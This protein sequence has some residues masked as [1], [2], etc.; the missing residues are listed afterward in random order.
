[1]PKKKLTNLYVVMIAIER[2]GGSTQAIHTE[3]AAIEAFGLT[4]TRFG[5]RKYP[6][7]ID[8]ELVRRT[9]TSAS[10]RKPPLLKGSVRQGW[11]LSKEG[12]RWLQQDPVPSLSMAGNRKG[13]VANALEVER[14][15]LLTTNAWHKYQ[16]GHSDR[17]GPNEFLE[18]VRINEYFSPAKRNERMT[19]VA[20]AVD[21]DEQ[22]S[23]LWKMLTKKFADGVGD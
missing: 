8:L 20:S 19:F 9:L 7:R 22:L 10:Q 18:F 1:V 6:E 14:A 11:M 21:G 16:S 15:R 5:W 2:L 13:S 3:D 23:K 4:P 12:I 17:I